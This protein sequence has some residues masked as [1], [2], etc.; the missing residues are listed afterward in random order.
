MIVII[1]YG[2]GNL[3]SVQKGFEKVGFE[4]LVSDDPRVIEGADKLVLP[5]VGAFR[6]CMDNLRQG[7]FIGPIERHIEAGRP[8]LGICLGLQL[9]FTESEE[10]GLH[11]GLNIIPGRVRRFPADLQQAGQAL[12][13]PHMGWNQL[14]IQ[15]PAPLFEGVPSG[16]SVYFV[17][18]YYVEPEDP[19]VV[20]A[21]ADYGLTFCAAVWRDNVMATQFHPEKSQQVGLRI[22]KNFG[23]M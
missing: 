13:V 22:L 15:R 6:D 17:H 18:S 3:R 19:S 23:G 1:D 20:A 16:E 8:F 12:K 9:L 5:G 21:T 7:G 2:M 4:A 10:F 14:A 11:A